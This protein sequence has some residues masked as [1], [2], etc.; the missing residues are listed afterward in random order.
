MMVL[1]F[2]FVIIGLSLVSMSINVVQCDKHQRDADTGVN[3]GE[4]SARS[5]YAYDVSIT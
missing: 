1:C 5:R 4:Y 2:V 3:N